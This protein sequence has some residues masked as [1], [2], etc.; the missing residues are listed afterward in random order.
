MTQ[1][2][3][4]RELQVSPVADSVDLPI[5]GPVLPSQLSR[6]LASVAQRLLPWA[7]PVGLIVLWQIA[8]SQ[9]WL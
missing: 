9:G 2:H 7:V 6:F 4:V 1:T 5:D 3:T 8:S